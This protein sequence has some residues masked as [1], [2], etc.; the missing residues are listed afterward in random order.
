MC[1]CERE[2]E[3]EGWEGRRREVLLSGERSVPFS[4]DKRRSKKNRME[5]CEDLQGPSCA[6]AKRRA[7]HF[8]ATWPWRT[9]KTCR[10]SAVSLLDYCKGL[11]PQSNN[12]V[13][14]HSIL[15]VHEKEN[16]EKKQRDKPNQTK[17]TKK[18]TT[19]KLNLA[20]FN[21]RIKKPKE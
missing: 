7:S 14:L 18:Q 16:K 3:R 8:T 10:N 11:C 20:L 2:R 9:V 5:A 13:C 19:T 1:V 21:K 12:D 15:K 17:P 6:G 4:A